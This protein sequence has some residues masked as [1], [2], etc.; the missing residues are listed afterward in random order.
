MV[1]EINLHRTIGKII[2]SNLVQSTLSISNIQTTIINHEN[3][4]MQEKT[5]NRAWQVQMGKLQKK[6]W[7]WGLTHQTLNLLRKFSRRRIIKFKFSK[8]S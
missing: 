7:N 3:K 1:Y 4:P 2:Y 6:L 8:R 5:E